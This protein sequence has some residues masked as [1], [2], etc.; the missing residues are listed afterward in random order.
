M[1][2]FTIRHVVFLCLFVGF[3]P[4]APPFGAVQNGWGPRTRRPL[5]SPGDSGVERRSILRCEKLGL[6]DSQSELYAKCSC[7]VL[8][9]IS[10]REVRLGC[11]PEMLDAQEMPMAALPFHSA[12]IEELVVRL[13]AAMAKDRT[14]TP[15]LGGNA[16]EHPM[17]RWQLPCRK[18]MVIRAAKRSRKRLRA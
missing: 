3:R 5:A 9:Q 14:L 15:D 17:T 2:L 10:S 11:W 16:S 18:P 7:R 13:N 12:R 6:H 1:W 4:R 8:I